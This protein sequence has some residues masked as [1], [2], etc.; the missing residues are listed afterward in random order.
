[1]A[2]AAGTARAAFGPVRRGRMASAIILPSFGLL[3]VRDSLR[4]ETASL[5]LLVAALLLYRAYRTGL[6][7]E[8]EILK[9]RNFLKQPAIPVTSVTGVAWKSWGAFG[10]FRVLVI[11]AG[12]E[13]II[14]RG[15]SE[16]MSIVGF[17]GLDSRADEKATKRVNLF[18]KECGVPTLI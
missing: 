3:L 10:A 1:M 14:V 2:K 8:G 17:L 5:V 15:V 9:V 6:E 7:C 16:Q 18:L 4:A 12:S 11:S 13:D